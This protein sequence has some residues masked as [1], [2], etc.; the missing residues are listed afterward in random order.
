MKDM[1]KRF[2]PIVSAL[3]AFTVLLSANA[4]ASAIQF[5]EITTEILEN[6]NT[7]NQVKIT[8]DV[9][10]PNRIDYPIISDVTNFG[11]SANFNT[12]CVLNK[13]GGSSVIS[14]GLENVTKNLRSLGLNYTTSGFIKQLDKEKWIYRFK[15]FDKS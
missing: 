12:S 8:F 1:M 14:C 13:Q 11:W 4:N 10:S 2:I 7:I 9:L 15:L 6:G 3:I 5:Y